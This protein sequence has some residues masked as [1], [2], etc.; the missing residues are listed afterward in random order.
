MCKVFYFYFFTLPRWYRYLAWGKRR[1]LCVCWA[2]RCV[3]NNRFCLGDAVHRHPPARGLGSNTC[4]QDA[5]NLA[6][7]VA[8]VEKGLASRSLLDTY[9]AERQPVGKEVVEQ[10]N[11]ALRAN[12]LIWEAIG[13]LPPAAD[14]FARTELKQANAA[15]RARR[16][17]LREALRLIPSEYNGLG[18]EMGQRYQSSGLYLADEDDGPP[19]GRGQKAVLDPIDDYVPSTYPGRRLPHAWLNKAV[20]GDV[21]S[22]TDLAGHGAFV[23]FTGV[24]G[25]AWKVAAGFVAETARVP[26]KAYSVGY[27]QDWEDVYSTWYD[28]RDVDES[29]AILV[30]PD[31]VVAWRSRYAPAGG[32]EGAKSKLETVMRS[33]LGLSSR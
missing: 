30:R 12:A 26:V 8:Y 4:I 5:Y 20:P 33:I 27:R 3:R 22:T 6:W 13:T 14:P 16:E 31:R 7:K 18:L 1:A 19:I 17:R 28:V 10:A 9:T 32:V 15:G 24:G 2:N 11:S 21:V 23:L 29:G 25:E